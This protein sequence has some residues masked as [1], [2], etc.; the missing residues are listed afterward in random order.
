MKQPF[1][2]L[3]FVLPVTA[4]LL[5]GLPASAITFTNDTAIGF[6]NTNYDGADVVVT[7]CTLTIDGLHSF[8]SLQVVN[9]GNLT[10]SFGP[11]GT[12][13][14]R[15]TITNEQQVLSVT[16][17]ATLSN[18]NVVVST[19]LVQDLL[20]LVTYTNDVDYLLGLDTNGMTT[21]LLT[22]NSAIAEGSTNLVSYDILDTPV[23]AGLSLT[24]T[25]DVFVAQGGRI[26]VDGK[27]YDGAL[28]PGAGVSSGIPMSG[29]GAGHGG[30]G[31]QSAALGGTGTA[32]DVLAQP[33]LLGSGGGRGY[34][35]VGGA[36]GGSVKL[37]VGGNLRIEGT[38]SANGANGINNRS[39][40]G[41]GGSIWLAFQSLYGAGVL[42][43]NGGAGE[44][45][46]GGGGAGG[47]ISL[48]F[49]AS[50][51]SG[52][53]PA[54]GGNGYTRGGAGTVYI[55]ANS[56][57]T[58]QVLVDN[59]GRS[60]MGTSVTGAESIDL[61]AQGGAVIALSDQKTVGN[62][63]VASNAWISLSNQQATLNVTGNATI[64][65]GGGITADGAGYEGGTGPGAGRNDSYT[66]TGGGGG[67]GGYGAAGG[68]YGAL[69]GGTTASGGIP[70]GSVLA[71]RDLG[72]GGGGYYTRG[73]GGSGGGAVRLS[74]SGLLLLDGRISAEGN[75][76]IG[77]GGGGGAGGSV[78]VTA[79][80]LAGA[81]T[82]SVN[83][84][85]GSG[86]GLTGGGG[87]GGGRVA[88]QYGTY[89][90]FGAT[91]A[92][93][94]SGSAW[95]G[96]GTVYTVANNQPY[97]Q[98]VVDNG[99]QS[100]TNTTWS[101]LG[102]ID[103]TVKGG[104][105]VTPPS[106]QTIGTLLVA[107]N[108]WVSIAN[109]VLTV[110]G[111]ATI[112]AGGG[113]LADGTG[114]AAGVGSGAGKY[115]STPSGYIGGGGGYGGYGAA[116]GA[117]AGY[118]AYGGIT[119]GSLTAPAELGSGGGSYSSI[120][121]GGAGGGAIRLNV[122]G[123]LL[124]D[125]RISAAGGPASTPNA[126][127][128][129]GGA[130][131][132]T[133]GT[134]T[135]SGIIAAN[136]GAGNYLGGGGGGGR[137]SITYGG[138]DFSGAV[139][140]YGGGGYA[141]GGAGTIYTT[142]TPF[143]GGE[144]V[145]D[146]GGQA[147]TNT[148][149]IGAPSSVSLIVKNGGVL[150]PTSYQ[151][152]GSL[153]VAS[154]GW[155]VPPSGQTGSSLLTVSGNATV[156]AG[157]GIIADGMGYAG[158][159][160]TGAGKYYST[161]YEYIG[162]GGGYGG[163]GASGGGT[164]SAYGG[165]TYGSVTAPVDLGS[166]GGGNNSSQTP[167]AAGGAGGGAIR[168]SV[169][170]TLQVDGRISARGLAG[171]GP[172]AGGGSG[173]SLY[174]TVG[175]LAGSGSMDVSGGAGNALG[176]GG[177]GGRIAITYSVNTFAGLMSA[178]GG[179]GY[180]RG[181]AGTVYTKAS[182]QNGLVVVDNGGQ[183][184]TNTSWLSTG[185]L[186]LTVKGGAI[187]SLPNS[188]I[189]IGNLLVAS[190]GW[191]ATAIPGVGHY[192]LT[193]TGNATIQAG[194]GIIADATGNDSDA[195]GAGPS[196]GSYISTQNGYVSGGGG[197]GG[198]GATSGGNPA[199]RGGNAF[200]NLTVPAYGSN[201]GGFRSGFVGGLGG[202]L[203]ALNVTGTLDVDGRISAT[204]GAGVSANAGGGSGGGISL[205]VGT[206]SGSGIIAANGGAGNGL[207][208]G[209]GGGRIALVYTV[210]TFSGLMSAYGGGGYAWGGAGTIY[211]KANSQSWGQVLVDNGGQ[212]GTNT[213]WASTGTMD[214]TVTGAAVVSLPLGS[215]T[216]GNLL[217]ASNGWL[218]VNT[219]IL[220]VSSNATIR[221]GG[222]IIADGTGNP[223]GLGTG[224]GK[225]V[226]ASSAYI[227]GGGGYGGYGVAGGAPSG[228]SAYGGSTYGSVT[229]PVDLGSGGGN[230]APSA[231]GGAGGGAVRL[232]VTGLLQVD[233][234][235]S[236]A[237]APG[238]TASAGGGSGGT[239]SLTAGTLAGSGLIAANG[240]DGISQGGGG[241]GGRIALVYGTYSFAGEVSAYGGTGY[242]VGGAG[243][244]YTKANSQSWGLVV[245]DNG[246][247][248]GTNTTLGWASVGTIDLTVR[249]GAVLTPPSSQ[250]VGTLLVASNGWVAIPAN[251]TGLSTLTLTVAGNA[252]VQAGGGILVDGA[253]YPGGQG[254]GMGKS[255]ATSYDYIGGGGGYGGYGA[256]GG[257]TSLAYGG[258]TYG[259]VTS[260]TDYG[261]GGGSGYIIITSGLSL[262]GGAG[263]GAIRL[264]VG[265]T[266][267]VDGEVSAR[268]QAGTGPSAGGGSGGSI[269]LSVGSLA[270]SGIISADGGAGNALGGG[271]G[272]GRI[273]VSYSAGSTF[274]GR[275]SAYGGSGYATGGAGT[276]F[277]PTYANTSGIYGIVQVDNG[278]QTGTNTSW[279][280]LGSLSDLTV[281]GGAVVAPSGSQ[282]IHNLTVASNGWIVITSSQGSVP[283]LTVSGNAIVQAG[284]GIIADGTGYGAGQ[285]PGLGSYTSTSSGY[286]SGGGGNGGYGATSGGTSAA[287]GG[288]TVGSVTIPGAGSGSGGNITT[289]TGGPGG[290]AFA[291][292]VTGTLQ[293]D[294]R[295]SAAGGAGVSANAG[296][297]AGGGINL[298]VGT[299]AGSGVIAANGGAGNGLSGG[300][301]GGRIAIV[302]TAN[303]FS[304][305]LSA[306]GGGGYAW[307][308]AG[309]IYTK[310]TKASWGQVLVDN[311]GQLGANTTWYYNGITLD[312]VAKGGAVVIPPVGQPFG[313]LLV[314]SNG[315]IIPGA[316]G[317]GLNDNMVL[318]LNVT[319]NATVQAGGGIIADGLG[320]ASGTG[321]GAGKYS[322]SA[323]SGYVGGG[324]GYGGLGA[325]SGG[326]S[327]GLGGGAYGT[328]T[329]PK[330][331]G[332]GGG[333]YPSTSPGGAGA[334]AIHM[335]VSGSLLINGRIS[336]NGNAGVG[337]GA[338][339]GSG[340]GVW[341]SAGTLAGAG[342]I[343]ANGGA[344]NQLGGG[345]GGGCVSIQYGVNAFDGLI[346]A[347]GG[348]GYASGGAGTV[349]LKANNQGMGQ[350]VLDNGGQRGTN[351]PIAYLS[352]LDLT[353]RGGAVAYPSSASLIF[354]NLVINSGGAFTCISTQKNIDVAVLRNA[355]IDAGGLMSVDGKGYLTASGPGAGVSAN[356]TGSGAGYGGFG[357]AS[358]ASAGGVTYGSAQQPIDRGSGGGRGWQGTSVG[359]EGGGVVHLTVGGALTV[360]GRLSGGGNAAL[361]DD[362]GG[363]SGG[364]IWLTAGA[365]AGNGTIAADGGAGELY[366]GGGGGGGRIAIYTP[367]NVFNGPVSAAG[368]PGLFPGQSGSIYYGTLPTAPQVVSCTPTGVLNAAVSSLDVVFSTVVNPASVS[369]VDFFLTA[370]GG[371]Q[372]SDLS[373]AA[374]SPY[375][376]RVFF[377]AQT[378][379]GDYAINVG[380]QILD[381]YGQPL[382]QVY[383]GAFSIVWSLVQGTVTDTNGLPAAGVVLQPDGGIASTTTD[384]NGNYRLSLPPDVTI[385]VTPA[386]TNLVF[387]PS[388][389]SYVNVTGTV[390]NEN[391]VAM[392][393]VTPAVAMQVQTNS[394][395]LS[396]NG[397]TGV[398]YQP[399]YSTNLVDWL[400][401]GD[402]LPGT[403]GPMQFV[404][405]ID[406]APQLYF[407][408]G[409][410]Y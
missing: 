80:T 114:N 270:G 368:G 383:T 124:V 42:S 142:R 406:T 315:W 26:N 153:L 381:L 200:G 18:A 332:S 263:G 163:Y 103:L 410:S 154:N 335:S 210:N 369:A 227:G 158:G 267:Q 351:T 141:C 288:S 190:N 281:S 269:N 372:V 74:V 294:G 167:P 135:G 34:G 182:N 390:S 203:I 359:G 193:V 197:Y 57:P 224:A 333:G 245:A 94:G 385:V 264:N 322:Y 304:G 404:M 134:L 100:G 70:Y 375:S 318:T 175:T 388:S 6:N 69:G 396:W 364:S 317:S 358:S 285:G 344:G 151:P 33:S 41:S 377:P 123:V 82:I 407:R 236:A 192:T 297:G 5:C 21:I 19:I 109:Q 187:L 303:A 284:G 10:H 363:G 260:P 184:G 136:G 266:L 156:Q 348:G 391:Y 279:S 238:L 232:N 400:P 366:D 296:G 186:D 340:G 155:V 144:I 32:Y 386:A 56:Q 378:A 331:A 75:S 121:K 35:G 66:L 73:V 45:A 350:L 342:T 310:A 138:Y 20:G 112:Q 93:G 347:Y 164:T 218:S 295:L 401:Y 120:A 195:G 311:G 309:T 106:S 387:V 25:G 225:Y 61:T 150:V 23:A 321:R 234:L 231:I 91:S 185:V 44:P 170:G 402:G 191:V 308:G 208:G 319:S 85:L 305:R 355:T 118:S 119:Y 403:N 373:V 17:V 7:N 108:G 367:M 201:G 312:L 180:A 357:G 405:P 117:P 147:G 339:G 83:G 76:A 92:R 178:G 90:F 397:I 183:A 287:R 4:L 362:G 48:Q 314:S 43:A 370:P 212:A 133:V 22:T 346:S 198:C 282:S 122:T 219:Q 213:T 211:T 40:G 171:T 393:T 161:S 15:R 30:Y 326:T 341:L 380:P 298:N 11:S 254:P 408:V 324:A 188:S 389:R 88:I 334:G 145:V 360:N 327:P 237:G 399:L 246:G 206:L 273:A 300:G 271:G 126:G 376:F 28:G 230:Y 8:A 13:E 384:T 140:A 320:N 229:A 52:L 64:Q 307:G 2:C 165:I 47:R 371:V 251:P 157:G 262:A 289:F 223:A 84:G 58:G 204:G 9:G 259:S 172:S 137:I 53:M 104:A 148:A 253:G 302:Y 130:I 221:A 68:A 127:G 261:S 248:A 78:W 209:G 177:G 128:G 202:G 168:L 356:S 169:T 325:A 244:I 176:G 12:L 214:L 3:H 71:P 55:R 116:G 313:N 98:L 87:G 392:S 97:G 361:Q 113:I 14:N 39:G 105:V 220:T 54:R 374:L 247:Q 343:S 394:C 99:G 365:L 152:I 337:Q 323:A 24:V 49:A 336:A 338:G 179:G 111:N 159:L 16:N 101:Q 215:Q 132:L 102:T 306:Y 160:G 217:V 301:G 274:C 86:F 409:A 243:T 51:F 265:G 27:G 242:A 395:V 63:L 275:I 194:G 379:Q 235:I 258:T 196:P 329:A 131:S 222:G 62:L 129:S 173:G 149:L 226:S 146:N 115:V 46:E 233:G 207:G 283:T 290:G 181:G 398:A 50:T 95:G 291:L 280:G 38:V 72:S 139:S 316:P 216:F 228:T 272:G 345:G 278:G 1:A 125:G 249:N 277:F 293:V 257:G 166:G 299:L 352:P 29:S 349:Y 205:T 36:G 37:F 189:T 268:G 354:S 60:G 67:Y 292:T 81:G 79:G 256:S 89:L 240:G 77:E 286:V 96:A 382:S 65:A 31:G 59:G 143:V 110:T 328:V 239:I 353:I 174:L 241:G 330:D 250:V 199:A 255:Y 107:S 276:I 162:G 252:K